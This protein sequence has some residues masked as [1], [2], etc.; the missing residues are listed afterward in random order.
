VFGTTI[1]ESR[2]S[3]G[4]SEVRDDTRLEQ[5]REALGRHAWD[6]SYRL[7]M[8]A[9]RDGQL[10][11]DELPMLVQSAYLA[12]HPEVSRET[13]ERAYAD[14]V[15]RGD[16]LKAAEAALEL[17][18]L[19]VDAGFVAQVRGWVGRADRLLENHPDSPLR[20]AAAMLRAS[21]AMITGRLDEALDLARV[22]IDISTRHED[23][24]TLII[25]RAVEARSLI[26]QGH[27]E[28]GLALLDECAV[29]AA[30]GELNPILSSIIYCNVVCAWQG[31]AEYDRADEWTQAMTKF[32]DRHPFGSGQGFCRVHRAEILRLR[33]E[34]RAAEQQAEKALEEM[35][36]Y[37]KG[38]LGWPFNELGVIRLR[39]GDL[40]G[41]ESAFLQ[42]HEAGWEPQPGLALLRLAQGNH[43]TATESINDALENPT[44]SPSWELP[45]N[46]R[47]RR[48][49]LLAAQVEIAATTGENDTAR[50]AAAELE[51]IAGVFGSRAIRASAAISRGSVLL[52]D[53]DPSAARASYQEGLR[54]WM[55]LNAPYETARARMRL[56]EAYRAEGTLE[57]A[58]LEA[59]AARSTFERLGAKVDARRAARL[60]AELEPR[61]RAPR[62]QKVLMFTDIVNSTNLV[63]AI[64]DEAW[65]HLLRWHN[66]KLTALV[67]DHEGEVVQTTGDG[68]FVTFDESRD[69]IECAVAI[70]RA[71]DEH[72]RTHGFSPR[73]RIGLHRAEATREGTDWSGVG[74]HAA[75]R[76]GA[77]AEGDEI[78]V[79]RGT[80]EAAGYAF[81]VSGTRSVS[82]KGI[83]EPVEVVAVEWR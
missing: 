26:F 47:L 79:S 78:L 22:A 24:D 64:G 14:A 76:I 29:A 74:V 55:K 37:S 46:T 77:L 13:W 3:Y 9:D 38:D 72:R 61:G 68:F 11:P 58:R 75:A 25:A 41:A 63:E 20:G 35:R 70:Q 34:C 51:Q 50:S 62:E 33:G 42:A 39:L 40:E 43:Q 80:A 65:G 49:P 15:R 32:V 1:R 45:P 73:V 71:L 18:F 19:L 81:G 17:A 12:G 60:A 16:T 36:T 53:G 67:A 66:Q 52:A 8:E 10:G 27:I 54:L 28:E 5:A 23:G 4:M 21:L 59:G 7:L 31:L 44:D 56:A 82:L 57:R 48:A 69:A 83:S 2:R 6:E 30:S